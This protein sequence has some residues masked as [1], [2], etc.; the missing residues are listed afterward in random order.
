MS[1]NLLRITFEPHLANVCEPVPRCI[2]VDTPQ[3]LMISGEDVAINRKFKM[4]YI[5]HEITCIFMSNTWP[6]RK[7]YNLAF[8]R[9]FQIIPFHSKSTILQCS[10]F[11]PHLALLEKIPRFIPSDSYSEKTASVGLNQRVIL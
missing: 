8:H 3:E 9:R 1:T 2:L 4:Q 7:D 6:S 11:E 5:S 10:I